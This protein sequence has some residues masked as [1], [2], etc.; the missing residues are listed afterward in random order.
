MFTPP[1]GCFVPDANESSTFKMDGVRSV[2][3]RYPGAVQL[4]HQVTAIE[5]ALDSEL[6]GLA[7][8]L[9]KTLVETVCKTVLND[10]TVVFDKDD[11]LPALLKKVFTC[12]RLFPDGQA[13]PGQ[14]Q[15]RL[16]RTLNGLSTTVQGLCEL[17]SN[18]GLAGHGQD[19][20]A[21]NLERV[22]AEFAARAADAVACFLW[23]AHKNYQRVPAV[24]RLQYTDHGNFNDWLD[25][26]HE[27][28]RILTDLEYVVSEVLF[29]VD[30][31]A[32]RSALEDYTAGGSKDADDD[33]TADDADIQQDNEEDRS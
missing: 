28:V 23:N 15:E 20:F 27:P 10:C 4:T 26:L 9:S 31:E 19:A 2:V 30:Q 12:L 16:K 22:Q 25:G 1:R 13:A 21:T 7:F 18:H 32:Y 8:D 14:V 33:L 3:D 11:D 17:R 5:Q 29:K 6:P 24:H